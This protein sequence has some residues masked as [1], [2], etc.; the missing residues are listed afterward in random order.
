MKKIIKIPIYLI[1]A[2]V[3]ANILMAGFAFWEADYSTESTNEWCL[4][5][6]ILNPSNST[7]TAILVHGFVGSP[8]DLKPLAE[9]LAKN[10]FKVVVPV[11]PGQLKK[12]FAYDRTKYSPSFFT[13]WLA[14]IIKTETEK[15]GKKPCL[16]GFSM[17]GTISTVVASQNSIEKLVLIAP[18]YSLRFADK[19][20]Y[21]SSGILRWVFPLV[22]KFKKGFINIPKGYDNY[23][24][25]SYIVSLDGY[26]CLGTLA[27]M[28]KKV[29]PDISVPV[30]V[31]G[32]RNDEV[33]SFEETNKIWQPSKFEKIIE[34]PKSNH[35]MFYD[36]NRDEII[37]NVTAFLTE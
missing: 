21:N 20:I 34:F 5:S 1:L 23:E 12:S 7:K 22:P 36:S 32:S 4:T 27:G 35:I 3:I 29:A 28:A 13:N 6:Q 18:F 19:F 15:N 11:L 8:F 26:K 2:V 33:A 10:N 9:S 37:S 31:V 25:G 17:G 24:C 16:V 30:L 14:E